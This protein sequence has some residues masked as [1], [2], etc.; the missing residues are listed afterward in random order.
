MTEIY[1]NLDAITIIRP[2]DKKYHVVRLFNGDYHYIDKDGLS[3]IEEMNDF[4]KTSRVFEG[5]LG[6]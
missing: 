6:Q 4:K 3:K 1:L 2:Y 5:G